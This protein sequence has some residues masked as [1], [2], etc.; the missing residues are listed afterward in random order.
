MFF[1]PKLVRQNG[2]SDCGLAALAT[3]TK[4]YKRPVRLE[5]IRSVSGLGA[6]AIHMASLQRVA[7]RI[8]F[9]SR[10]V[11]VD[12]ESLGQLVLPSVAH[13]RDADG[14]GHY[15]VV[16]RVQKHR[17]LI[18]DPADGISWQ[19]RKEFE[20]RWTGAMLLLYPD[21]SSIG[22]RPA[23]TP[24]KRLVGLLWGN[25]A[26]ILQSFVCGL[27]LTMMGLVTS[28]AVQHLVDALAGVG[29]AELLTAIGCAMLMTVIARVAFSFMQKYLLAF[30]GRRFDLR[31][32]S[33]LTEKLLGLPS[34]F[35]SGRQTGELIGRYHD[36][37][38]VRSVVAG[39]AHEVIGDGVLLVVAGSV[40][41]IYDPFLAV[42]A[43]A[44]VPLLLL[45]IA[46]SYA[47]TR[48]LSRRC[49]QQASELSGHLVENVEGMETIQAFGLQEDRLVDTQQRLA[50]LS[51]SAFRWEMLSAGMGGFSNFVTESAGV[52]ILWLGAGRVLEGHLTVGQLM[53]FYTLS[54]LV[55]G[56]LERLASFHLQLQEA[57]VA[58]DRLDEILSHSDDSDVAPS[59]ILNP[60]LSQLP[61]IRVEQLSF[62]FSDGSDVLD[63]VN[64]SI[65]GGKTTALVGHSGS[66]KSTLL[67][68]LAGF[69][70]EYRGTVCV[71]KCDLQHMDTNAWRKNVGWVGQESFFFM[72]TIRENLTMGVDPS[73]RNAPETLQRMAEMCRLTGADGFINELPL[74]YETAL[75]ERGD[76]LS[77]GQRQRLAIVRALLRR[78][79][80]LLLDEATSQL[81]SSAQAG[82]TAA[83]RNL[84]FPTTIVMVAHRLNSIRHA[85]SIHVL[86]QGTIRQ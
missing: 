51:R 39:S 34:R 72:G 4:Y 13:V 10:G 36:I 21:E 42:I 77:G 9:E 54:T 3:I 75:H 48:S 25:Q 6:T 49:M 37:A 31:A 17:I 32:G 29:K 24:M 35:F 16:F 61:T 27:M 86:D 38:A 55:F 40:L 20:S 83:L 68:L 81:D 2:D 23:A 85:D 5:S 43:Y 62:G 78:P 33:E 28:L 1:M 41:W 79:T 64:I 46:C 53:F 19:S 45:A 70:T 50:S 58:L 73:M 8:G 30:V 44:F 47:S 26:A 22:D 56:P 60:G 84:D 18:G 76:N 69:E 12:P 57:L 63:D 15:V 7:E 14:R 82:I 67:R 65:P 66:G 59:E 11:R 80:W 74:G 71:D 52:A